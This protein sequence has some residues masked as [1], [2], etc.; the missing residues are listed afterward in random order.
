MM[1]GDLHDSTTLWRIRDLAYQVLRLQSNVISDEDSNAY[2]ACVP[3]DPR[4]IFERPEETKYIE[5]ING[6]DGLPQNN[7]TCSDGI[8]QA[9]DNETAGDRLLHDHVGTS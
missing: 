7:E 8:L 3:G 9:Q 1:V 6:G 4:D 2:P 5:E